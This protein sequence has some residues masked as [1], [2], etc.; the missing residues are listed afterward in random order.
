ML[1]RSTRHLHPTRFV[2]HQTRWVSQGAQKFNILYMGRDEFSCGVF[3]E[4]FA[5]P[6]VWNN[7]TIATYPDDKVGRRGSV[8]S[9]SPLGLLGSSLRV[10]VHMIPS[11][12]K[13]FRNWALPP[14]FSIPPGT[15]PP[16]N[17]VLLTASF[18]RIL[19][20]SMLSQFPKSQ[21]LNV[22][23]SIL[24]AYRG[25]AP[26][27]HALMRGE[28]ET[29][30]CVI[31]MLPV[32]K[33]GESGGIDAGNIWG[34]HRMDIPKR[35]DF[36][37]VRDMLAKEGGR[38]LVSVLRDMIEG[39]ANEIPQPAETDEPHAPMISQADW[40]IDFS[41]LTAEEIVW[42]HRAISHHRNLTVSL[43]TNPVRNVQLMNV[44][45][46]KDPCPWLSMTPGAACLYKNRGL[47]IRCKDNTILE[48]NRLKY[49]SKKAARARDWWNGAK[50]LGIVEGSEVMFRTGHRPDRED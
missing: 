14:P 34:C 28:R 9:V 10:P 39:T 13:D 41:Q 26:I 25:P 33:K 2:C 7:I 8:L 19:P 46:P 3:Q 17:H 16:Q 42:R 29:G 22:H 32:K 24:P 35:A 36:A 6:D 47:F 48:V 50:G 11:E 49:Q 38:L 23:P 20:L 40:T 37:R 43:P 5:A 45:T 1:L 21:R 31:G 18:G 12:K 4:L 15:P 30:V 27:Q 44:S